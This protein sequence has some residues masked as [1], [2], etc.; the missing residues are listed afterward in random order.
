MN[1]PVGGIS[2]V[3]VPLRGCGQ[4]HSLALSNARWA[5]AHAG[6]AAGDAKSKGKGKD[7]RA[8]R[9]APG[10]APARTGLSKSLWAFEPDSE[11][12]RCFSVQRTVLC[13]ARFIP[14]VRTTRVHGF[15]AIETK[16]VCKRMLLAQP[17]SP[18]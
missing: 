2:S 18:Y 14:T 9:A 10:P 8:G 6:S 1:H 4:V 7:K 13:P 15:I 3:S 12:Q 5:S 11:G 17:I 16:R